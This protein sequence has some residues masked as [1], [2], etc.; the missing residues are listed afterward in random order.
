MEDRA[1]QLARSRRAT[2][3]C[4]ARAAA[5]VVGAALLVG[6]QVASAGA[7]E[8][9]FDLV[10][11]RVPGRP[12]QVWPVHVTGRC[13]PRTA[14]VLV[15]SVAGGPPDEVRQVSLFPC[16]R[17]VD[18]GAPPPIRID[19]PDDVMAV[20]VSDVDERPGGELVWLHRR[21]VTLVR[22][23]D[24]TPPETIEIDDQEFLLMSESDILAVIG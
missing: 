11:L 19:V 24:D 14:D 20:D 16:G 21:G 7:D 2:S 12:V 6:T 5:T 1:P 22:P 4:R 3:T 18:G 23:L 8:A 17:G 13:G 15:I 9:P 10:E